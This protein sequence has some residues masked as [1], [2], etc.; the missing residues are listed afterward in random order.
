[1]GQTKKTR[2][3]VQLTQQELEIARTAAMVF[4][5]L[6]DLDRNGIAVA[7]VKW[8]YA[9]MAIVRRLHP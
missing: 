7:A 6:I 9:Q 4:D 5:G 2:R 8:S 1:M 3:T